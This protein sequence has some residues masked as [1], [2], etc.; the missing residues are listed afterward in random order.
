M[1]DIS[2]VS[3]LKRYELRQ[4]RCQLRIISFHHKQVTFFQFFGKHSA[5]PEGTL[6]NPSHQ[7]AFHIAPV[8]KQLSQ[9]A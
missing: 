4:H 2:A 8:I 7:P 9:A 3:R 1:I 5:D 6:D